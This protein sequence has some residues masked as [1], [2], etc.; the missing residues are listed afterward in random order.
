MASLTTLSLESI[1]STRENSFD[2][3]VSAQNGL[4]RYAFLG[5]LAVNIFFVTGAACFALLYFYANG[6]AFR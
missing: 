5:L 1:S 6:P 4:L 3:A 2:S